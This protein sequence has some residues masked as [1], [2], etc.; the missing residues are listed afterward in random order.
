M[1]RTQ[2]VGWALALSAALAMVGCRASEAP[3]DTGPAVDRESDLEGGCEDG[4][5]NDEDD[6]IDCDDPDCVSA[7]RADVSNGGS[8]AGTDSA[9]P[10]TDDGEDTSEPEDT[11]VEDTSEPEDTSEDDTS[12]LEDTSEP[13]D[14]AAEDTTTEDTAEEDTTAP[15]APDDGPPRRSCLAEVT[16]DPPGSPGSVHIAGPFNG[17]DA[18]ATPMADSDGDGVFAVELDLAP[19]EHPYKFIVDGVWDWDGSV[20]VPE[21]MA[22][23]FYTQWSGGFENRNVIVGDCMIPKLE[24]ISASGGP[25]G[26]EA[27]VRFWSAA[28]G[29]ALDPASVEVTLG[30]EPF[31]PE[32]DAERGLISI[33]AQGL[34]PGKHSLRV[35]ARDTSGRA[36]EEEPLFVPLW[37]EPEPFQWQDA[38]MYFVF[39]DR[40]RDSDADDPLL[41][42]I[43]G[44]P[45]IANYQGGDFKGV[46]DALEEG[47]FEAMG[48]NLLWLSPVLENPEGAYLAADRFHQFSGFHGYWPTH[49]RQIETRWGDRDG[50][51]ADRLKELIDK[52][53]ARG[54]RVM[55]DVVLNHVHEDHTYIDDH[56]DWFAAEPC[57]CTSDPGACNWDTNPIFCWFIDYLPDLDFRN[58]D[59]TT[60]VSRDVEWLVTEFDVDAFRVD[61]AKH[62]HHVIMRRVARRLE[63]RFEQGGGAAPFYLVGET[64][65]GA[66]GHGLIMNYVA[67]WELDGQFDFP[68]LY[69]I[70]DSF[71]FSVSF[72]NLSERI[73]VGQQAYGDAYPWMSPFLG[74]HDIPRIASMI[75]TGGQGFDPWNGDPDPMASPGPVSQW[76]IINRMSMGFAF[77]ITQPGVPL[78]YYGDEIGLAGWAD[79][80]NRRMMSFDLSENQRELLGRVQAIGAARQEHAA[81]RRGGFRELWVDDDLFIYARD[82]GGGDVAIVA[83]NKGADRAQV[84]PIPD[85]LGLSGTTLID[86]LAGQRA[87]EV[88]GGQA[89]FTLN[90]W[91]Y[92]IFVQ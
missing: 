59:V 18:A 20:A 56:P 58:H 29:A 9:A 55:F 74:N 26:I 40:F 71:A 51:A 82:N 72:R 38:L 31:T 62:M 88:L 37:V 90:N 63:D 41:E 42:P 53:H 12:A 15:D 47:Y 46:I 4:L 85:D 24:A 36:T 14:T 23:D 35:R 34:D 27:R 87:V 49:P 70:R 16:Y 84:V 91:E 92:A 5:D 1:N 60:Q 43:P 48:V 89:T 73:R 3:E 2:R 21:G 77:V 6:F 67:P 22:A 52:A 76:E 78:I 8:D 64:F 69:P 7:C 57:P 83:M 86:T 50:A 17:W 66:D 33:D 75:S 68:L 39:T 61:A 25:S 11:G 19:G 13:E 54:I 10:D 30:G 81:L 65:T 80:D 44:V 32:I 79:P 28:D 45:T